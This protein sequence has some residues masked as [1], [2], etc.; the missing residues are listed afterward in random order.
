L[1]SL[2]NVVAVR[3]IFIVDKPKD[4]AP[5]RTAKA[6]DDPALFPLGQSPH[7]MTGVDKVH[8]Q[9]YTGKGI[10]VAIIDTGIDYRHPNLGGGFGPGFKVAGGY[11][12]VG[13]DYMPGFTLPV[14]DADPLD[15]CDGHG[16][17]VAGIVAANPGGP[18]NTTGVAPGA[19]LHAYRVFSCGGSTE[20]VIID[21]MLRAHDDGMDILHMSVGYTNGWADTSMALVAKRIGDS[22]GRVLT[23]SAGNDGL[24]GAMVMSTPA[25]GD[26]PGVISVASVDKCVLLAAGSPYTVFSFPL[27]GF[28]AP[29][30]VPE[31]PFPIYALSADPLS[32]DTA[33][34]PLGDDVL[35]LAG[36][37]VVLRVGTVMPACS[38]CTGK[39]RRQGRLAGHP[40]RA[41]SAGD[42][43]VGGDNRIAKLL[44]DDDGVMLVNEFN[45]GTKVTVTFTQSGGAEDIPMTERGGLTSL[46]SSFG[47]TNELRFTPHV[48]AP[49]ANITS[50]YLTN[51]GSWAIKSG[52]S[53]SGPY[54]A[55]S[56]ALLL[57]ANGRMA[58][59]DARAIFEST[60]VGVS[61]SHEKNAL[62]QTLAQ[63]GAGLVNV[64]NALNVQSSVTPGDISLNDT[65]H[66]K[67]THKFVVKNNAKGKQ[68]YQ[69]AHLPAGTTVTINPGAVQMNQWPLPLIDAPVSV[70]LSQTTLTLP[71]GSSATVTATFTPP[72]NVDPK[73]FPIVSGWIQIQGSLGDSLKVSYMGVAASTSD[74]QTLATGEFGGQEFPAL[75]Y[76]DNQG[77]SHRVV[78]DL[79]GA[80]T[81]IGSNIPYGSSSSRAKR[82]PWSWWWPGLRKA[83]AD[84]SF[85]N[86]PILGNA[87]EYLSVPRLQPNLIPYFSVTFPMKFSNGSDIPYGQYK[88]LLRA[89]RPFGNPDLEKDYD[90][91]V[92][93]QVGLVESL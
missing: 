6:S 11:D 7:I 62:L 68:V 67:G 12:F 76:Y 69:L 46:Y 21:G 19:T 93:E 73:T 42:F 32:E 1:A 65:T 57:E 55:G 54:M 86:V 2:P 49:G 59:K 33:C 30:D 4:P 72:K 81:D 53:M 87:A 37:V 58:G 38:S 41:L 45:K 83:S 85:A 3:P 22:P 39:L 10:K 18:Y 56:V 70:K 35:D 23:I 26:S 44:D 79:V 51:G 89:L 25:T 14:P 80:N 82:A 34:E 15:T 13:D 31:T 74:L 40:H 27:T 61:V 17:H 60:S 8:A 16:T 75:I 64:F 24:N 63:Q 78:I 66:W 48:A 36:Y 91:Y 84:G 5:L 71:P 29:L 28:L 43:P 77:P 47:P 88:L 20:D 90:V 9:G 52:T 50:T 92:S